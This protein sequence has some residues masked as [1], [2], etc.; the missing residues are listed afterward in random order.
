MIDKETGFKI[1]ELKDKIVPNFNK[2][3]WQELGM[4]IGLSDVI[5]KHNRLLRS[6]DF[7]D[8][9]YEGNVIEVL[10]QFEERHSGIIDEVE[11]YIHQKFSNTNV[12]NISSEPQEKSIVFTPSVFKIPEEK[13]DD[14]LVSVM[15]PFSKEYQ[16][17]YTHI[18]SACSSLWLE[19]KR[20]DDIWEDHTF[21]QDIFSLIYRSKIVIVDFTGKN[22][23]VMYETGI[24]HTLGKI[25]IP[26]TQN[27]ADIPSDIQH[28][29][30]LKYL[31]NS[32]GL[33]S[34]EDGLKTRLK[35]IS[36]K[37]N[38]GNIFDV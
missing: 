22:P 28:H 13:V 36:T 9:D 12:V 37:S 15:M 29:R 4:I 27:L 32:E 1:I 31:P 14:T 23:N 18:K 19:C 8:D 11:K 3:H 6:L 21:I 34:L 17:V 2:S 30:A 5:A 26:I 7:G 24:A 16:D 38:T 33:K 35:T 20:A 25:V 10:R